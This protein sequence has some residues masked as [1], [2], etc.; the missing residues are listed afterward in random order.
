MVILFLK[1]LSGG[2]SLTSMAR[3]R[4]LVAHNKATKR[5][6]PQVG[7]RL[8]EDSLRTLERRRRRPV[9]MHP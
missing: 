1:S 7:K 3:L 8:A 6:D 4:V 2:H 5:C 9:N